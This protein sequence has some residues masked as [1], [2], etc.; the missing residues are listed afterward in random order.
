MGLR[1]NVYTTQ[2]GTVYL[3]KASTFDRY[4]WGGRRMRLD[5]SSDELG[6]LTVTTRQNPRGG[7][8]RDSILREAPG[9]VGFSLV[10]KHEQHDRMKTQLKRKFW[11]VDKRMHG[12]EGRDRDA[13]F[14]WDEITRKCYARSESRSTPATTW[15]GEE[16]GLITFP[17]VALDEYDIY[18][19]TLDDSTVAT[20]VSFTDVTLAA[21][22]GDDPEAEALFYAVTSLLS[23]GSPRLYVNDQGGDL[24]QW[25]EVELT[26]WT[27]AG[28]D[29]VL[30][31][32]DMVIIVSTGEDAILRSD[33]RG[34][35]RVEV[36]FAD[37]A[38]NAIKHIDGIDQ[39]FI[40]ACG[41]NGRVWGSYDGGR[42]WETLS[43]G[44]ATTQHLNRIQI[45]RSNPQ[46]IY[47]IGAANAL[48]KSSNGGITWA[49]LTG[50]SAADALLGLWA[51][52]EDHL[53]IF[54]DDGELWETSDGGD[55]WTQQVALEDMPAATVTSG[56]IVR[57]D[58]DV[59]YLIGG[60]A[61]VFC[62]Y[63]NVEG[64]ADGYWVK[65]NAANLANSLKA[66]AAA[67]SNL[68]VAVGGSG[69]TANILALIS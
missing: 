15:E 21:P 63:R 28:A 69:T 13:P 8:E 32:G 54:N 9:T 30:G 59:Y 31:I 7:I 64:G 57:V 56:D 5:E 1:S 40:V 60:S 49:A 18:Q 58:C 46:V 37:W 12:V 41:E 25:D 19:V 42:T 38:T 16:E 61:S 33:D 62:A 67:D 24:D 43:A 10:M 23:L 29:A 68:A 11:H 39:T 52:D 3:K 36:S 17:M 20:A 65:L 50:P 45:V 26:E 48:I 47:A 6:G 2:A 51:E 22:E 14:A 27:T 55:S 4:V 66:V 34:A 35:S 44:T 53:L